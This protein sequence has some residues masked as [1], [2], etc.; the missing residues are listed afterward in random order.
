MKYWFCVTDEENWRVVK[1]KK[2]WGVPER[3]KGIM[4][5]VRPGDLLVFYVM[6]KRIGGIFRVVSMPFESKEEIFG[7]GEYGR[8]ELFPF[9]VSLET[10]ETPKTPVEF[11][12]LIQKLSF[13]KGRRRWSAPLRRGMFEISRED[14]ELI[15][16]HIE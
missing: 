11:E 7:W 8:H 3:R 9:R 10:V 15:K 6:P 5:H 12:P 4:D 2:I 16:A 14:Y 13:T 1:E